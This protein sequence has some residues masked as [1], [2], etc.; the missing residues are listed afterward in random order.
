MA[1]IKI[2]QVRSK[3]GCPKKQKATLEALGLK[4]INSVVEHE[5]NPVILGMVEAVK[6]LVVVEK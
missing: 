2:K 3:I 1:K 6:H 5:E 4:K